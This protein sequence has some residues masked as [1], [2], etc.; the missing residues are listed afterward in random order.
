VSRAQIEL[1]RSSLVAL[2]A[3]AGALGCGGSASGPSSCATTATPDFTAQAAFDV[4]TGL[5]PSTVG[6][7]YGQPTC[8]GQY[9]VE[10][11][12]TAPA[13][14]GPSTFSVSGFWSSAVDMQSCSL[15]R[16]TMNVYV[17]DGSAWRSWDVAAYAGM[18][19]GNYCIPQAQH[20]DPGS[21][22]FGVTN[23]PLTEGFQKAR[24]AVS[25]AESD[26]ALPVAVA[27]EIE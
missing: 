6:A 23:V 20:T 2:A 24:I 25:A 3:T 21:V 4:D 14:T 13:F 22:S 8:P 7:V 15:L 9:L 17:L 5:A 27:G 10:V 26:T 18:V 19:S 1:R 12:L 11:D 16:A